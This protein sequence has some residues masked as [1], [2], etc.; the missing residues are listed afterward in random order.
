M[1]IYKKLL[2]V[3]KQVGTISKDATNP[4]FKYNYFDINKL[5][6]HIEPLLSK[7]ELYLMQPILDGVQ[8]SI[9]VD[10]ETSEKIESCLELPHLS[11]PQKLGSAITYYRR[12]TLQS[13]LG[14]KAEDD[15]ANTATTAVKE[16]SNLPWL[17]ENDTQFE[18]IKARVKSG[19]SL[20]EIRKH[21][22][23]STKVKLLLEA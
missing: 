3:Q 8:Y 22:K 7:N 23:I 21:Y 4:H 14:L 10:V 16:E 5:I 15:D 12:Y 13:L 11:D 19:V 20:S 2:E 1:S 17:N 9:I 6:E 18:A